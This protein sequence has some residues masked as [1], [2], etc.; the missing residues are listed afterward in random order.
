MEENRLNRCIE[1]A[2][3]LG[4]HLE[5]MKRNTTLSYSECTDIIREWSFEAERE[6][7]RLTSEQYVYRNFIKGFGNRK[8]KNFL[9]A[10][11]PEIKLPNQTTLT[12]S[13]TKKIDGFKD[14]QSAVEDILNNIEGSVVT[15]DKIDG[16]NW[17]EE[18][19][20]LNSEKKPFAVVDGVYVYGNYEE[21]VG[22][23]Y[24]NDYAIVTLAH[25]KDKCRLYRGGEFV[26]EFKYD[27]TTDNFLKELERCVERNKW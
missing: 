12:L 15:V 27:G 25:T 16:E 18:Y 19:I 23:Y 17:C 3:F 13:V 1:N 7:E 5:R 20:I 10:H 9:I 22:D 21:A 4:V 26:C 14:V 11:K 2:I 6:W 24:M 8:F